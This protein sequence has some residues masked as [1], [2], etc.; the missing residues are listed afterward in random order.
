MRVVGEG[1]KWGRWMGPGG[2]RRWGQW[3]GAGRPHPRKNMDHARGV[4][5]KANSWKKK[6][7]EKIEKMM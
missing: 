2:I 5:M 3:M 6:P 4:V 1:G 7:P